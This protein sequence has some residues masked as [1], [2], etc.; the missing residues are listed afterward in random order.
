[1]PRAASIAAEI[2]KEYGVDAEL[3]K[4]A[5]GIFDVIVDGKTVYSKFETGRHP[6]PGEV[7]RLMKTG[8]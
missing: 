2:K 4:G 7:A 3:E 8:N 5:G 6:G 1:M